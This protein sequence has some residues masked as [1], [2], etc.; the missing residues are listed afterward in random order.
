MHAGHSSGACPLSPMVVRPYRAQARCQA[1]CSAAISRFNA[2]S[3]SAGLL[4]VSIA[5]DDGG[6]QPGVSDQFGG[7]S[8]KSS[9]I[10]GPSRRSSKPSA[11][12]NTRRWNS[13]SPGSP[14]GRP[15]WKGVHSPRGGRVRSICGRTRPIAT[16]GVPRA[17][18]MCAS[19][20][21][22]RV[23]SGQTGHRMMALTRSACSALAILLAASTMA[24]GSVDP[25]TV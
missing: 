12:I 1:E 22:A 24:A 13:G 18:N 17:S 19:A 14:N 11:R 16:V 9:R 7:S 2:A 4:G 15:S 25:I 6:S 3:Q 23:Q 5:S 20:L 10:T 8:G 21:T